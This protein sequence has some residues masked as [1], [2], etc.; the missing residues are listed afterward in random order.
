MME[1]WSV[2]KMNLMS[3]LVQ[4]IV[5]DIFD[6]NKNNISECSIVWIKNNEAIWKGNLVRIS[7][8]DFPIDSNHLKVKLTNTKK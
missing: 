2:D 6:K 1:I 4:V 5:C 3:Q 8:S 7:F